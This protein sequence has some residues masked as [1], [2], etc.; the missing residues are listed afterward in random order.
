MTTKAQ[1]LKK[2]AKLEFINDQLQAE[3]N[4]VDRLMR[5][6]GFVGGLE[7]I[8]AVAKDFIEKGHTV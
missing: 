1:L 2:I 4:Y 6:V 7:G 5:V 8:K 3:V